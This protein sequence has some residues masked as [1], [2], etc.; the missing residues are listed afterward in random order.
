[1]K[2]TIMS[3]AAMALAGLT[4]HPRSIQAQDCNTGTFD[5][6]F[7][8]EVVV[9]QNWDCDERQEFWFTDQGSQILPYDWFL[10]LEQVDS[11]AKFSDPTNLD[12]FRY[13]PQHPTALNPD[14]LP[15]GFT[16]GNANSNEGLRKDF[17]GLARLY[18]RSLPYGAGRV[19]WQEST[20]RWCARDG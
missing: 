18:L 6:A 13:L 10:H 9:P 19:Q 15:I 12:R 14:G 2:K 8:G 11:E 3:V 16:K 1:M 5:G 7:D 17:S 4:L 20:D